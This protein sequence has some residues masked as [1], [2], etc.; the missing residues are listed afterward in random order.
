MVEALIGSFSAAEL[1]GLL[2]FMDEQCEAQHADMADR[3]L[4]KLLVV[5]HKRTE[6]L[7]PFTL[8]SV[9]GAVIKLC[10]KMSME[11]L[12]MPF[13]EESIHAVA[14]WAS[15]EMNG[16]ASLDMATAYVNEAVRSPF[17]G[18][19]KKQPTILVSAAK[20]I[21]MELMSN[22]K[23][24]Q[25]KVCAPVCP[26]CPP[27]L[28]KNLEGV[29][30]FLQS[31]VN[32]YGYLRLHLAP[33]IRAHVANAL[34]HLATC[35]EQFGLAIVSKHPASAWHRLVINLAKFTE[36]ESFEE[37]ETDVTSAA[38]AG[39]NS[40]APVLCATLEKRKE[41]DTKETKETRGWDSS[42]LAAAA[43]AY[44]HIPSKD[45]FLRIAYEANKWR[46]KINTKNQQKYLESCHMLVLAFGSQGMLPKLEALLQTMWQSGMLKKQFEELKELNDHEEDFQDFLTFSFMICPNLSTVYI[47]QNDQNDQISDF[48]QLNSPHSL[49]NCSLCNAEW[50]WDLWDLWDLAIFGIIISY[51]T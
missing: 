46:Q 29:G 24:G 13:K 41:K 18:L 33:D 25:E 8:E 20:R 50:N 11:N 40:L 49:W 14:L 10:K 21:C 9:M 5:S 19:M 16:S 39:L 12:S 35:C 22:Q 44:Q 26:T 6:S 27:A 36:R 15:E 7:K 2:V 28:E 38:I 30:K 23:E 45:L 34:H 32:L 43:A 42:R 31:M 1:C 37:S 51:P 4:Q 17:F 48:L 3:I 47:E